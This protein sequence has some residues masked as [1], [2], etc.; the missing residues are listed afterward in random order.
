MH[1]GDRTPA[2]GDVE[3]MMRAVWTA[4]AVVALVMIG[5]V[6]VAVAGPTTEIAGEPISGVTAETTYPEETP[7]Q[8]DDDVLEPTAAEYFVADW[9]EIVP[10]DT[11]TDAAIL[12]AAQVMCDDFALGVTFETELANV[13]GYGATYDQAAMLIGITIGQVC[14]EHYDVLE[15]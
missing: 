7:Y 9:R 8:T 14:P 3:T 1:G 2:G 5:L 6:S 11:S 4:V 12:G 10:G 13:A 15:Q